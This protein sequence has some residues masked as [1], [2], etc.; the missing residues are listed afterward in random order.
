MIP[1]EPNGHRRALGDP[2]ARGDYPRADH[3]Q[4]I[5]PAR[6]PRRRGWSPQ[7]HERRERELLAIPAGGMILHCDGHGGEPAAIPAQTGLILIRRRVSRRL[8]SAGI[9]AFMGISSSARV[10]N[11]DSDVLHPP[12]SGAVG[13]S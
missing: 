13:R 8:G 1:V 12:V 2:R 11:A 7:V 10:G 6:S 3:D 9:S 4:R 5:V